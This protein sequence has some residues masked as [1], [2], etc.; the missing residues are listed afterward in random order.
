MFV[1]AVAVAKRRVDSLNTCSGSSGG[2][3]G[4]GNN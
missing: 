1:V 2:I 3:N 4:C